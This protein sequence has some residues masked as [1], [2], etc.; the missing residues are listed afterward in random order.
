MAAS[1]LLNHLQNK[2]FIL[3][4]HIQHRIVQGVFKLLE[5]T[6]GEVQNQAVKCLG[7]LVCKVNKT[8][9]ELICDILHLIYTRK[10]THAEQLREISSSGLKTVI[11]SLPTTYLKAIANILDNILNSLFDAIERC[12]T[13]TNNNNGKM[14]NKNLRLENTG[15]HAIDI[16]DII[17][18]IFSRFFYVYIFVRYH[19]HLKTI[20]KAN[21]NSKRLDI[22]RQ[23]DHLL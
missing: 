12:T 23:V 9:L 2:S 6:N 10:S 22:K 18:D 20:L 3:D 17:A 7:L 8:E 16:L 1:D 15:L 21:Q 11:A 19:P 5:D 13:P 14:K 4:N